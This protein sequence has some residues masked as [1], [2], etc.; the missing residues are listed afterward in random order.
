[1]KKPKKLKTSKINK[2]EKPKKKRKKSAKHLVEVR[3]FEFPL[4]TL[5]HESQK[6]FAVCQLLCEIYNLLVVDRE[7]NRVFIKTHPDT[8]VKYLT[9]EEQYKT[10]A[11]LAKT[12]KFKNI[13]SQVLQNTAHKID[14]STK[15][16]M[17]HIVKKLPG[18]KSPP[19]VQET[20]KYLSFTYPEYGSAANIKNG[21]L[22]LSK[23]GVFKVNAFR[24]IKGKPK[25]LTVKFKKGQWWA[26][27]TCEIVKSF[28]HKT[29]EQVKHLPNRGG[30]T[31][32]TKLL[33]LSDGTEFDPP[34]PLALAL[35]RL[36]HE[37]KKLSRQFEV[38]KQDYNYFY[39]TQRA[40]GI[41]HS[42]IPSLKE[43]PLSNRL[44]PQGSSPKNIVAGKPA[45]YFER[46]KQMKV[47]AKL[48]TKVANTRLYSHHKIA[49]IIENTVGCLAI[50]EHSVK[51]MM[52]NKRLAKAAA[53]RG[54]AQLK[55]IV[56]AKMGKARYFT[57]GTVRAGIGGNSQTCLCN[58]AV[59][60]ELGDRNHVCSHCGLT[61]ERDTVSANI[62]EQTVF[63]TSHLSYD[64]SKQLVVGSA[65]L[66]VQHEQAK[67]AHCAKQ[68]ARK[69]KTKE[70]QEAVSS[71][72]NRRR[73]CV[74]MVAK[75][76]NFQMQGEVK[77]DVLRAT[78][79]ETSMS[80][81]PVVPVERDTCGAKAIRLAN[82][83]PKVTTEDRR[84]I[85]GYD[86]NNV[87]K[88]DNYL[89]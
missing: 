3:A 81:K 77:V 65:E 32:L 52:K 39:A 57:A 26:I 70:K 83:F 37:Q 16:W 13:H 29:A 27:V 21:L 85:L 84:L 55:S 33:V 24:K 64:K 69:Q 82:T 9:R 86:A 47:V 59:P 62:V 88:V 12:P 61:A 46:K 53:D 28:I 56:E 10:V 54:I 43:F 4:E 19:K 36:R 8:D 20:R 38:R 48:H 80:C 7:E 75:D 40:L 1:M 72:K 14:K 45:S 35:E 17:D 31:G 15:D 44:R 66:K 89:L 60:K 34:K 41:K 78:A 49:S 71:R 67:T 87:L 74:E 25:S 5:P 22:H 68:L 63:G 6:L 23:I 30:D 76:S 58:A 2:S 42:D 73:A 50:E 51:F 79:S 11:V 18:K